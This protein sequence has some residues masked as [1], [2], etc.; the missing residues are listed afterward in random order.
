MVA[1]GTVSGSAVVSDNAA[2]WSGTIT[3]N[4]RAD[5]C[6]NVSRA[7]INENGRMGGVCWVLS[8]ITVSGTAQMLGDGEIYVSKSS[9]VHYGLVDNSNEGNV[10]NSRTTPVKEVT[11]PGPFEW[12]D[13]EVSVAEKSPAGNKLSSSPVLSRGVNGMINM[14]CA[15]PGNSPPQLT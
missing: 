8:N 12:Y 5:G 2:V 1:G 10:G 13:V 14:Y 15:L 7:T 3:D 4:G 6:T 9:G 11:K